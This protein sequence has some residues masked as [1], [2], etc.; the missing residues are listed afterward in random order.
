[1]KKLILTVAAVFSLT[2]AAAQTDPKQVPQ[3]TQTPAAQQKS[4]K[5]DI[6]AKKPIK[7][8][9]LQND[10]VTKQQKTQGDVQPRKD[11]IKTQNHAKSTSKPAVMDT[12]KPTMNEPTRRRQ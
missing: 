8:A 7:D 2:I 6:K 5:T 9:E 3:P 1:M 12:L 4:T 10:A 11:E